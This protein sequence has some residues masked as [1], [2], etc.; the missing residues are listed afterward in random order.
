MAPSPSTPAARSF[1]ASSSPGG[2]PSTRT[3]AA[4]AGCRRIESP[5]PMSS[6]STRRPEVGGAAEAPPPRVEENARERRVATVAAR[7]PPRPRRGDRRARG[8]PA[9][10]VS[11]RGEP[12]ASRQPHRHHD[13]PG[14]RRV[15]A[16]QAGPAQLHVC[17]GPARP[18]APG[19][20]LR[21]VAEQQ[22]VDGVEGLDRKAGNLGRRGGEHPQPHRRRHRRQRQQVG[23]QRR[24][25]DRA[26]VEGDQRRRRQRRGDRHRGA[27]GERMAPAAT[28]DPR[29]DRLSQ[30]RGEQE[31][32]DHRGEAELPADV[33]GDMRVDRQGDDQRQDERVEPRRPPPRQRRQHP[34]GAHHAGPLDRRPG[35]GER[36]VERDQGQD[37]DQ[38]LAQ[39]YP[40][41]AEHRHRQQGEQQ[42][43]S[44]RRRRAGG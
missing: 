10:P 4:P 8:A 6:T 32:P 21:D 11:Q 2:P 44:P 28:P 43:R 36:D 41:S 26:E 33:G 20:H 30:R 19:R 17:V 12:P 31:D 25:R 13:R 5:W 39:R 24:G 34:H 38:A 42:R 27:L 3:G 23:E 22:R 18:S 14:H 9:A 29:G 1:A 7:S 37:P 40:Q 16:G 15:G 35:P